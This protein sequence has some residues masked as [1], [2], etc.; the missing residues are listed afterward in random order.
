M[1]KIMLP[2]KY[3]ERRA[4]KYPTLEDQLDMLWHGMDNEPSK[5]IEPFYSTILQV[6]ESHPKGQV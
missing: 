2:S 1:K 5:R 4:V 6:K 3:R